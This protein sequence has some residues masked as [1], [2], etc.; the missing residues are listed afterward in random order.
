MEGK[1]NG[2]SVSRNI[3]VTNDALNKFCTQISSGQTSEEEDEIGYSLQFFQSCAGPE[4][5]DAVQ[6]GSVIELGEHDR[7]DH[8]L[9]CFDIEAFRVHAMFA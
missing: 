5:R 9:R 4:C 3:T 7:P 1:Q 6:P 2:A 8:Q